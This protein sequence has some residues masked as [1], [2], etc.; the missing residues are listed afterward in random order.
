[1]KTAITPGEA[2]EL[3]HLYEKLI[4]AAAAAAEA[5]SIVRGPPTGPTL[6]RL[7]RL[8]TRVMGIIRRINEILG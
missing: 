3:Q 4:Y 8:Y 7:G 2:R 6:E 5:L 1:M